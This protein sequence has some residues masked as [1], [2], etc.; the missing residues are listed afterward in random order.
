MGAAPWLLPTEFVGAALVIAYLCLK[1]PLGARINWAIVD[2]AWIVTSAVTLYFLA[3]GIL[4]DRDQAKGQLALNNY[5]AHAVRGEELSDENLILFCLGASRRQAAVLPQDAGRFCEFNVVAHGLFRQVLH[6]RMNPD[7]VSAIPHPETVPAKVA[8][9]SAGQDAMVL[10]DR[11]TRVRDEVVWMD[12]NVGELKR[13]KA[14]GGWATRMHRLRIGWLYLY[15]LFIVA[16]LG[17]SIDDWRRGQRR[18]DASPAIATPA[19]VE[20]A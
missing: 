3:S 15:C 10:D 16:R 7:T 13:L 8:T 14:E 1:S 17:K 6:N 5:V 19:P 11:W 12:D 2:F 20:A 18:A 4:F 9:S